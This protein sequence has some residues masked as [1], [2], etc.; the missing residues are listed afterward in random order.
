MQTRNLLLAAAAVAMLGALIAVPVIAGE[1]ITMWVS[2]VR[3]AYNGRSSSSPDRV[4]AMV[5]VRDENKA[6][7]SGATVRAG[8]TLPDGTTRE[9]T[10]VTT[11]QGI[12]T[13]RVWAGSGH[14]TL[15]VQEVTR[16]EYVYDSALNVKTCGT[17]VVKWPYSPPK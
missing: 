13:F 4:V 14:Y 15:C 3:L 5:H 7:V 6:R 2:N 1:D 11:S 9:E 17:L 10:A 16:A 12:A 8:W